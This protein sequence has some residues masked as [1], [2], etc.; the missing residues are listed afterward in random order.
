MG[1]REGKRWWVV[2]RDLERVGLGNFACQIERQG[3]MRHWN[4]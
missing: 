1:V 4:Y 3:V 2:I